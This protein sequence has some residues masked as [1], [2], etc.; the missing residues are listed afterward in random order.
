VATLTL[1]ETAT[2]LTYTGLGAMTGYSLIIQK[3]ATTLDVRSV[4]PLALTQGQTWQTMQV[5]LASRLI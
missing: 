4:V 2:T 1:K 3:S 5:D